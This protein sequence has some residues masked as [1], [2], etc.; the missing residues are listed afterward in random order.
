MVLP[1]LREVNVVTYK[2]SKDIVL[3]K[4]ESLQVSRGSIILFRRQ[5]TCYATKAEVIGEGVIA[6]KPPVSRG[7]F[8]GLSDVVVERAGVSKSG[9]VGYPGLFER[10]RV[11]VDYGGDLVLAVVRTL[12][13]T[14]EAEAVT[15]SPAM[16]VFKGDRRDAACPLR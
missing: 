14:G 6:T 1:R 2:P 3:Q 15:H 5:D 8:E 16:W 4:H 12:R 11:C 10:N 13:H 7:I 9:R